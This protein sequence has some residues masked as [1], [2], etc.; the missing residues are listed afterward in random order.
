MTS[1]DAGLLTAAVPYTPAAVLRLLAG[2]GDGS[3]LDELPAV[4]VRLS[5]G[6]VLDGQ[7]VRVGTDQGHEVVVLAVAGDGDPRLSQLAYTLM[8]NV[9]AVTVQAPEPY[10][11][12]LSAG[13]LP[14]P[15]TGPPVTRLALQRAYPP[16]PDFPIEVAWDALPDSVD[17]LANLGRLLAGL[18]ETV[19]EVRV[20]EFGRQ[21]WE[22]VRVV[23][24]EHRPG[25]AVTVHQTPV[26]LAVHTDLTAALPRGLTAELRRQLNA[27]L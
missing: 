27:L 3:A 22:R 26:G 18:R 9:V 23:A 17:A 24:V 5:S 20:D 19:D 15:V 8:P 11:D 1:L 25:T 6:H 12:V 2:S 7:L 14:P 10:R 4:T 21:A 13:A 16:S